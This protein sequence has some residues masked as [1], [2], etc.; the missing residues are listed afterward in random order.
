M[1]QGIKDFT[2]ASATLLGV[3]RGVS[4]AQATE[5]AK[6]QAQALVAKLQQL[7]GLS[8]TEAAEL[9]T[10]F[11]RVGF[12]KDDLATLLQLVMTKAATE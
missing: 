11:A 1:A 8:A 5:V 12:A 4:D 6:T 3:L 2:Q 7:P 10:A 9:A